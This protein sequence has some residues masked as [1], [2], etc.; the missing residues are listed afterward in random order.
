MPGYLGVLGLDAQHDRVA[1][2]KGN[3]YDSTDLTVRTYGLK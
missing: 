2:A 3:W 1:W